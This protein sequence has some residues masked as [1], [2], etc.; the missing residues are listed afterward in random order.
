MNSKSMIQVTE[1]NGVA[2]DATVCVIQQRSVYLFGFGKRFAC[3]GKQSGLLF[4]AAGD[5]NAYAW[6]IVRGSTAPVVTFAGVSSCSCKLV[7]VR[8]AMLD[9]SLHRPRRLLA[10]SVRVT[11]YK[12]NCDS[13]G[14]W[15]WA[16]VGC[17]LLEVLFT[18]SE[19]K[20]NP[21]VCVRSD[22]TS[23]KS[24]ATFAPE[25]S[26]SSDGAWLGAVAPD[27]ADNWCAFGSGS[28]NVTV[29]HVGSRIPTTSFKTVGSVHS[30]LF[31]GGHVRK[32]CPPSNGFRPGP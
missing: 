29:Y 27:P 26:E 4:T 23:G 14:R 2:W 13:F 11:K 24:I 7:Q 8:L 12:R 28:G 1:T 3:G 32:H 17:E 9:C 20:T 25:S 5:S 30:L 19:E 21:R 31:H 10:R 22:V 15:D 16:F 18:F 6:D